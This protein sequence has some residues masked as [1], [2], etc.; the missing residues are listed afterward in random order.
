MVKRLSPAASVAKRQDVRKQMKRQLSFRGEL[1]ELKGLEFNLDLLGFNPDEMPDLMLGR[2]VNR[3]G[4]DESAA[5]DV[6]MVTC[7]EY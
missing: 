5:A 1:P 6:K 4:Y 3:P 7:L 2:H